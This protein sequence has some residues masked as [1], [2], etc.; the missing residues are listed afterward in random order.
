MGVYNTI[1]LYSKNRAD[2]VF[3]YCPFAKREGRFG[4]SCYLCA[5]IRRAFN[6]CG[7]GG[8]R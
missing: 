7:G 6:T 4:R 3:V 8:R 2:S 5:L 1:N